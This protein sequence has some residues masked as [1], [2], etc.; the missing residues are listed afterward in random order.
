MKE[1]PIISGNVGLELVWYLWCV[2]AVLQQDIFRFSFRSQATD[3][4]GGILAPSLRKTLRRW[5]FH[6]RAAFQRSF[7]PH[8]DGVRD[9]LKLTCHKEY[10]AQKLLC[11]AERADYHKHMKRAE[12][13]EKRHHK[14]TNLHLSANDEM[15]NL[16]QR[17]DRASMRWRTVWSTW[18]HS[19]THGGHV[20]PVR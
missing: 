4:C 5:Q 16:L 9:W 8:R 15:S 3:D 14:A 18:R 19:V 10:V 7:S 1:V 6:C 20:H 13:C 11:G 12:E 17:M 2:D